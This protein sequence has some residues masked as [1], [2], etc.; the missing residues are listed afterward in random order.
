MTPAALSL[1]LK[2]RTVPAQLK[3]HD[4]QGT[5]AKHFKMIPKKITQDAAED[6]MSVALKQ[7]VSR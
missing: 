4:E 2:R 7:N 5:Q 1:F 3:R 6:I